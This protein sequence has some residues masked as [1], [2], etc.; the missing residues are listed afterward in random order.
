MLP[1]ERR[2]PS[3]HAFSLSKFVSS[4]ISAMCGMDRC[5]ALFRASLYGHW[6]LILT[7]GVGISFIRSP[8]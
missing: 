7:L 1:S 4:F 8:I 3:N 2:Y 6:K 5:Q